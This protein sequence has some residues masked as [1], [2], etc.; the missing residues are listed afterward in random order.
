[1]QKFMQS[2]KIKRG[3]SYI[4][5]I[6]SIVFLAYIIPVVVHPIQTGTD[7]YSHMFYTK[8]MHS[9][10]SLV[11][12]YRE[13]FSN[14]Y[15]HYG[16]PFGIWLFGST[17]MKITGASIFHIS[18]LLPMLFLF[19]LIIIYYSYAG[20]FLKTK[21]E[22]IFSIF[23]LLSMPNIATSILGFSASIFIAPV[24][25]LILY[26][27]LIKS[28]GIIRRIFLLI[29]LVFFLSVTHT[30][31]YMF[32]LFFASVYLVIYAIIW[33]KLSR[34]MSLLLTG[35]LLIY[36]VSMSIFPHVQSQY[37]DKAR[38]L[39][40][41]GD[42]LYSISNFQLFSSLS[43]LFYIR[44]FVE[45]SVVDASLW[46]GFIYALVR[47][48]VFVRVNIFKLVPKRETQGI[49]ATIPL[50]GEI[51]YVSHSV[52]ATP[53]W[54][55]PVQAFLSLFGVFQLNRT[56]KCIF[57]SILMVTLLPGALVTS[58]TGALRE[59]YYLMMII[60]ITSAAG[61]NYLIEK[62][63][64]YRHSKLINVVSIVFVLIVFSYMII[65][66]IIGNLYYRPLITGAAYERT[67]MQGLGDIG[68]P[69]EGV[70]GPGYRHIIN[71]YSNKQ[72]PGSTS[73]EAGSERKQFT[74]NLERI[75]FYSKS[76]SNVGDLY[77]DY[78]IK[79]YIYSEKVI[80]TFGR[81]REEFQIDLNQK[82]DKMYCTKNGFSV[83]G[84][85][86]STAVSEKE[87]PIEEARISYNEIFPQIKD[88][89]ATFLIETDSYKLEIG[90]E[91]PYIKYLGDKSGDYLGGGEFVDYIQ[92]SGYGSKDINEYIFQDTLFDQISIHD[93]QLMYK[94]ILTG[95]NESQK[96]ATLIVR[97]TFYQK[98]FKRE[99]IIAN[100]WTPFVG[101]NVMLASVYSIQFSPMTQF[102]YQY[103]D[104]PKKI[105]RSYP[106][107][108]AVKLKDEKFDRVYFNNG[109]KGIYIRYGKTSPAP[110]M[111]V[112]SGSILYNYSTI[113]FGGNNYL[114]PGDSFHVTQYIAV[115][116]EETAEK[117]VQE[118]TAVQFYPYPQ[119][120]VPVVLTGYLDSL[121]SMSDLDFNYS[122]NAYQKL[123]EAGI[124]NYTEGINLEDEEIDLNRMNQIQGYDIDIMGY[125]ETYRN[126]Y[127]DF[128]TQK[129]KIAEGINNSRIYYGKNITG[130]VTKGLNY[131]LDTIKALTENNITFAEVLDVNAPV[132]EFN[133]EGLGYP[134]FAYYHGNQSS[135]ILLPVSKPTSS[136]LRPGY[137][138]DDALSAWS[139]TINS[140]IKNDDVCIFLWRSSDIGKPVYIDRI[141]ELLNN[142]RQKGI[143][144]LTPDKIAEHSKKLQTISAN[145]TID[146]DTTVINI[147]NENSEPI[148]GLS[149]K[150]IMPR[151]NYKCPYVVRNGELVRMSP[152]GSFCN[153]YVNTNVDPMSIKNLVIEPDMIRE[154]FTVD[155]IKG[156]LEGEIIM[157][158]KDPNNN[159]VFGATV[160]IDNDRYMT[161]TKGIVST[162][163]KR[164]M[165]TIKVE[166]PGFETKDYELEVK[167]R[168]HYLETISIWIYL[169]LTTAIMALVVYQKIRKK[170]K[171]LG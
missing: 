15:T 11:D 7:V 132:M 147:Q 49:A 137:D 17:I 78:N 64:G 148:K 56:G 138:V 85:I 156:P 92:L 149:F 39:I 76:E 3:K 146:V 118:Y 153:L 143:S 42:F 129:L 158:V 145:F 83:Y 28:S 36:A 126:F 107:E 33:G 171:N 95:K 5:L 120:E 2:K 80:R 31:T 19:I 110:D 77:S 141:I 111:I 112:F 1:M 140:V 41:V 79:Y 87:V 68:N 53:F 89:E 105:K 54:I 139:A 108:D 162:E 163:L 26:L 90:K 60:P 47:L 74:R 161:D 14:G 86:K 51:R 168:I 97:Y 44:V 96:W 71:I 52:F 130:F 93:N 67:G 16:Y 94:T 157:S 159:T 134:R 103:Q 57:L 48:L 128:D 119:G 29:L 45:K 13:C 12:F 131:N 59:I 155:L 58:S 115:G 50:L 99:I 46:S 21:K 84:M 123:R 121:N 116:S 113:N 165:Y 81:T 38:L 170:R 69:N 114:S 22:Q 25:T 154:R 61:F 160:S 127:Y 66:P 70:T 91:S 63:R 10:D 9:T 73:V 167:G 151:V 20:I 4:L 23:F 101:N 75:Y 27:T 142:S 109:Q 24:L 88:I 169:I 150:V 144:F 166:K 124:S 40:T 34:E 72:V 82:L 6:F 62:I 164:G 43:Q 122:L 32:L 65:T 152:T 55:G 100:D 98:I 8:V 35:I 125:L 104:A 133:Q 117:N 30:G 135:L 18:I 37:I 102:N 106:S 136:Y